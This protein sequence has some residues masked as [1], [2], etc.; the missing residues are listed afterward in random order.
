MKCRSVGASVETQNFEPVNQ[1]IGLGFHLD[2][3]ET[4]SYSLA[5]RG[6]TIIP[7]SVMSSMWGRYH[8]ILQL[9]VTESGDHLFSIRFLCSDR[10]H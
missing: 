7:L 1:D 10:W 3:P 8:D 2:Q 6:T 5:P 9:Q 4:F